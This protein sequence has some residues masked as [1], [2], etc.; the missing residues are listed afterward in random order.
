MTNG[1]K[2]RKL[3][4]YIQKKREKKYERILFLQSYKIVARY[5][6]KENA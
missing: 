1:T 5:I 3:N 2:T 4:I 6:E